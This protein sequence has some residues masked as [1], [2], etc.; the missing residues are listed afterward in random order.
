VAS[1]IDLYNSDSYLQ[2]CEP[3][4]VVMEA[5]KAAV[6]KL[7]LNKSL[8]FSWL[9]PYNN[10]VKTTNGWQ[11]K[12]VPTFQIGYKGYIQLAMR[13]GQYKT[14]NA[15]KVFEGEIRTVDK[16]TGE[17][18]FTGEKQSDTVVG[19]FAHIVLINGFSKTLY[20]TKEEIIEHAKRFSKSY[21]AKSSA[22]ATDFDAMA[23]K[24]VIS[25]LL[26]HY[27]FLSTEMIGAFDGE[28]KSDHKDDYQ[29]DVDL[30]ANKQVI[31]FDDAEVVDEATGEITQ[32]QETKKEVQQEEPAKVEN[33]DPGF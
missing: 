13:T 20:R 30:H 23:I 22:W 9:V 11:K 18:D 27:G 33:S 6:L 8:G 29:Q 7:P 16:L 1:V 17:I 19:Y 25:N 14:I 12:L 5:L 24:T 10:S 28:M 32:Q 2:Q 31:D 3:K 15:D 26:S 21:N 4:E